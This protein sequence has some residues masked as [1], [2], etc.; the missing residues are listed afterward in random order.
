MHL[1]QG[2]RSQKKNNKE[3]QQNGV[4]NHHKLTTACVSWHLFPTCSHVRF[5][6]F[7]LVLTPR[8]N[9]IFQ[10]IYCTPN[11]IPSRSILK[12]LDYSWYMINYHPDAELLVQ[13][14]PR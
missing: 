10:T 1:T 14:F 3:T 2:S 7:L 8:Y 9:L 4:E 11:G 13:H 6:V 5:H 12:L